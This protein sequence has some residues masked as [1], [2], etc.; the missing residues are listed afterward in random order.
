MGQA[1]LLDQNVPIGAL[2]FVRHLRPQWEVFHVREVGLAGQ[3]DEAVFL[4]AQARSAAII[5]FDEDFSDARMYPLGTHFGIVRLRVWPTTVEKT[6]EALA[7]LLE[8]VADGDWLGGL[9]II[10][11]NRIRI[12]RAGGLP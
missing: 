7:R 6:C 2:A 9:A 1:I 10:D 8:S 11:E 12:R 5:T 4:W 3:S